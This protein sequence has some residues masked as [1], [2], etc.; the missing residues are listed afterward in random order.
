MPSQLDPPCPW[1]IDTVDSSNPEVH[2]E[3][4]NPVAHPGDSRQREPSRA[5]T[6]LQKV[7]L[8]DVGAMCKRVPGTVETR[9]RTKRTR[10]AAESFPR[11]AK[12]NPATTTGWQA[13]PAAQRKLRPRSGK[14]MATSDIP[15]WYIL[16]VS[17]KINKKQ[18][19]SGEGGCVQAK[20]R[21][22]LLE[23]VSGT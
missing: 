23:M 12:Q 6:Q 17:A 4:T 15:G 11:T 10:T 1:G 13:K 9:R 21:K 19:D 20:A 14:S 5:V 22:A 2:R 16:V 18:T 7:E 3:S 8:K